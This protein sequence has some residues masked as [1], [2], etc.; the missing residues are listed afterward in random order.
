[1][2]NQQSLLSQSW[3]ILNSCLHIVLIMYILD[4]IYARMVN[5]NLGP[6]AVMVI[7]PVKIYIFSGVYGT[8]MELISGEEIVFRFSHFKHNAQQLLKGC[9]LI[10][11]LPFI[12]HAIVTLCRLNVYNISLNAFYS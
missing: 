1:M 10:L 6:L 8:F 2:R 12:L 11:S 3:G 7:V 5:L 4:I 9:F